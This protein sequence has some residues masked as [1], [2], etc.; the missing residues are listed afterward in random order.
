MEW[1]RDRPTHRGISAERTAALANGAT[2]IAFGQYILRGGTLEA[3]MTLE[4]EATGKLTVLQPVSVPM[5]DIV[6]A[7]SNLARQ[8]SAQAVAYGTKSPL[9]VESYVK[10]MEHPGHSRH[11]RGA[12]Q[13]HRSGPGFRAPPI[14]NWRNESCNRKISRA[15]RSY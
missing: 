13:G 1:A 9:V 3:R 2:Q 10:A 8:I 12:D 6:A 14:A 11:R 5:A 15:P 4:S 7:A